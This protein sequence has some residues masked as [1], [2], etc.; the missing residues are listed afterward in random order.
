MHITFLESSNGLTLSKHFDDKTGFNN[1]P[2]VKS[3]TSHPYEIKTNKSGLIKL[4]S[5]IRDHADK[6]H[7]LL[8]GNLKKDLVDESRAGQTSKTEL[9]NL[10]VLDIDGITLSK[11][12]NFATKKITTFDVSYISEQIIDELPLEFK[13]T[14]YIA[15]ASASLGLKSNKISLHIFML[16]KIAMP[17]KSI[18]LWLQDANFESDI[19]S[20]QLS[21]SVNGQSLRYPLDTSVADNSKI[22]F[23]APPTFS[24]KSSN[25]FKNDKDRIVR[26][27]KTEDTVN[28]AALMHNVS[29]QKCFEK[30][31]KH[32]DKLREQS[33]FSKK[34]LKTRITT[35]D[36]ESIEI[37]TNP[38]KMS[39]AI[40]DDSNFPYIRCNING[41]DSCA[42]YFNMRSPIYMYNFKGEPI[43]EIEKADQEFFLSLQDK[44][45]EKLKEIGQSLKPVVFRDYYTDTFFNGVYDPNTNEFDKEFPLTPIK[46]ANIDDFFFNH[47][48][49]APDFIPDGK[50]VFDPTS[51][52]PCLDL[53]RQPYHVNT[54]QTTDYVKNPVDPNPQLTLELG[55]STYNIKTAC[56]TIY[57]VIYHMLGDGDEEFERFINWL[58]YIYQTRQKSGTCWVLQGTQGTG[59]GI[60]YSQILSPLF[61]FNH[62]PMKTLVNIDEK[63]NGYMR[64][65]IFLIVDEF[66]M[67][68]ANSRVTKIADQL[69]S[70]ITEPRINVREM[71]QNQQFVH[72]YT[73][74]I[75]LTNRV[76]AV[77]LEPND[78]RYNIAPR[79]EQRILDKYPK[80]SKALDSNVL[81]K[82]L[83]NFSGMLKHFKY[84]KKLLESAYDNN[85]KNTM[86]SVSMS[87]FEEFCDAV[88]AGQLTYF[89]DILDINPANVMNAAEI[90]SAQRFVKSWIATATDEYHVVPM[91]HLRTVYHI[92]TEQNPRYSQ[93][94]FYKRMARYNIQAERKRVFGAS[95]NST[96]IRGVVISWETNE[97]QLKQLKDQYFT[98]TDK[99]LLLS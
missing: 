16:L 11:T 38:D 65:A 86:R 28:L 30:S 91:E 66:H 19:F 20:Q 57:K 79:Q 18:K 10:L 2:H 41:G 92:I 56:P 17:A 37:I 84:D 3:V 75:F 32:K 59:K 15:Q 8:K 52:S 36:N 22:I 61:G 67:A 71:Y 90:D 42:Y 98:E 99:N 96:Q 44:F 62:V 55:H 5:L 21:L 13:N 93:K 53:F 35:I 70:D 12:A 82:E 40:V 39:I 81:N 95:R 54:Y 74:F 27:T 9:T 72:S 14:S 73:N 23:I 63:Y 7:C 69:K 25:P 88:K 85:A 68:S 89:Q 4:E 50:I 58:S 60:F 1:Y 76:D 45:E 49:I 6:G 24:K 31:Q 29:P 87:V 43:F 83:Y 47:G 51:T 48:K 78:R 46:K 80:L 77:N 94:E 64:D 26:V 97:L 33:G 34:Q